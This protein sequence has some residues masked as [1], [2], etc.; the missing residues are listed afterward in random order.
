MSNELQALAKVTPAVVRALVLTDEEADMARQA[1]KLADAYIEV[2]ADTVTDSGELLEEIKQLHKQIDTKR[3][4]VKAPVL[5]LGKLIDE[6]AKPELAACSLAVD[7]LKALRTDYANAIERK[8]RADEAAAFAAA[9]AEGR[10][11]PAITPTA[12]ASLVEAKAVKMRTRYK[13]EI[14]DEWAI[15]REYLMPDMPRLEEVLR[16][17]KEIPGCRWVSEKHAI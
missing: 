16:S 14:T 4:A 2:T 10:N 12:V 6:A 8:R 17:G 11:T 1:A 15:P 5:A 13:V 7:R 3:A 9:Q